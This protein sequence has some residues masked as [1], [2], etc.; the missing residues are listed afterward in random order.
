MLGALRCLGVWPDF[1]DLLKVLFCC[2]GGFTIR[3]N[4]RH[5]VWNTLD[6]L[7]WDAAATLITL[8]ISTGSSCLKGI[9]ASS[10]RHVDRFSATRKAATIVRAC[11][12]VY[13]CCFL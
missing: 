2:V 10:R 12:S 9:K 11:V 13:R 1:F 5:P 8:T 4:K 6:I 7:L 3:V